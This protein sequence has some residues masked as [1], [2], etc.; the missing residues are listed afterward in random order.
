[1]KQRKRTLAGLLAILMLLTTLFPGVTVPALAD[2]ASSEAV[3][4]RVAFE[5]I[6]ATDQIAITMTKGETT[7]VLPSTKT[8][9]LPTAI[10]AAVSGDT[11]TTTGSDDYIW[12]ITSAEGGSEIKSPDGN[13]LYTTA[14]NNGVRV[15][16]TQMTW[17]LDGNYLAAVDPKGATR[18]LGV[19]TTNPDWRAY[20]NTTN[21]TAGQSV[22]FWKLDETSAP[23]PDPPPIRIPI[24]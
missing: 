1:M 7:W 2:D 4:N 22:S 6:Q 10:V 5:D 19:Y 3:W 12:N 14:A 17:T 18:W 13:Y 24:P 8:S 16:S 21:N 20:T 11:L 23:D 9:S 15:G